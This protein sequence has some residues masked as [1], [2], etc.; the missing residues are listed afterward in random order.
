MTGL[1]AIAP[2]LLAL[3][4]GYIAGRFVSSY[5]RSKV[6]G[7]LGPLVLALLFSIGLAFGGVLRS[8]SHAREALGTALWLSAWTTMASWALIVLSVAISRRGRDGTRDKTAPQDESRHLGQAASTVTPP[9]MHLNGGDAPAHAAAP[10]WW[11]PTRECGMALAMVAA[12]VLVN[13][14]CTR[15]GIALP[16]DLST[17][18]LLVLVGIV[19]MELSAIAI[20]ARW[21]SRQVLAVPLLVIAGSLLGGTIAGALTSLPFS[22]VWALS[23][24]F[25]WFTLS[26]VM[27]GQHLG[28]QWGAVALLTDLFR[29]LMSVVLLYLFGRRFARACIGASA[30]TALDTTLPIIKQHCAPIHWPTAVV[31]GFVLSLAAPLMMTLFLWRA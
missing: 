18:L 25:G 22:T 6:G 19:G 28:A 2:I 24:G 14:F 31:S 8:A 5:W 7:L 30:A 29:E 9:A 13:V 27:I 1:F 16:S 10:G 26:G 21:W 17:I 15:Q 4:V 3:L 23:S 20:D 11:A 12:G